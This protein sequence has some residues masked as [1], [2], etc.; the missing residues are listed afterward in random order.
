MSALPKLLGLLL[1]YF[2]I[3]TAADNYLVPCL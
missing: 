3:N 1:V 2:A